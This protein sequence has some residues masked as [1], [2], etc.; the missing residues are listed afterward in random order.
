MVQ[1]KL[2]QK[3][4]KK[5]QEKNDQLKEIRNVKSDVSSTKQDE[6]NNHTIVT[7]NEFCK[8]NHFVCSKFTDD[9]YNAVRDSLIK[10]KDEKERTDELD[11]QYLDEILD[12]H[13]LLTR[14]MMRQ[15]HD[16][17]KQI[18]FIIKVLKWR[19]DNHISLIKK[20]LFPREALELGR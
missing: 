7:G 3:K 5:P 12:D 15:R 8:Q 14:Y 6:N 17:A 11:M 16:Q 20:E 18:E 2:S 13:H 9:Q 4:S 19:Q 10:L 1:K